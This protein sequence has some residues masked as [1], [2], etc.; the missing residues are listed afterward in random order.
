MWVG[1][2]IVDT[3]SLQITDTGATN[4]ELASSISL[5]KYVCIAKRGTY[6]G[7]N[8]FGQEDI[9]NLPPALALKTGYTNP[10][11]T[12]SGNTYLAIYAEGLFERY[13][14]RN[15]INP[16]W[17][18]G[19]SKGNAVMSSHVRPRLVFKLGIG[20]YYW[21][22]T[23]WTTGE[24][25]FNIYLESNEIEYTIIGDKKKYPG[26]NWNTDRKILNNIPWSDWTG[27]SGYKIPLPNYLDLNQ[28]ITFEL[29]VQP[30]IN[31][32]ATGSPYYK[33][34]SAGNQSAYCWVKDLS[35][36]I[37]NKQMDEWKEE[38]VVYGGEE[39]GQ[40]DANSVM[41]LGEITMKFTTFPG[42]GG[43][44]YSNVG[45]AI[46]GG[47]LTGIIENDISPSYQSLK[48]EENVLY[49]YI[50]QYSSQT[51][52]ENLVV[53][54]SINPF[55]KIYDEYWGNSKHFVWDGAEINLKEARQ[56]ITIVQTK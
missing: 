21:D 52:K 34:T 20:D 33:E 25:K 35:V 39:D 13:P 14:D 30:D 3:G 55:Q 31:Y 36:K 44:S 46:N 19:I 32:I 22:G 40:I 43:V 54:M 48:P 17:V 47:F 1:G 11:I 29:C 53:D 15:Y 26:E 37:A 27:L 38:D 28:D 45:D 24:T 49:K 12:D 5:D 10:I 50:N 8:I 51:I 56:T 7:N 2:T 23:D 4:Y 41:E 18:E 42:K 6:W 16:D 9:Q